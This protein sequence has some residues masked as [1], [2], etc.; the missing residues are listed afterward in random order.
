MIDFHYATQSPPE[1]AKAQMRFG[2]LRGLRVGCP[3][4]SS[5]KEA[6]V[7]SLPQEPIRGWYR[8]APLQA[9]GTATDPYRQ[10]CK[11]LEL[12]SMNTVL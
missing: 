9:T 2:G 12:S 1:I 6:A 10:E 4:S 7:R 5:L 8:T 11:D 3:L